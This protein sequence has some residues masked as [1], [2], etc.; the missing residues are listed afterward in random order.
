M[1]NDRSPFRTRGAAIGHR[2]GYFPPVCNRVADIQGTVT[3]SEV[4]EI[5]IPVI[6][7]A[8][9]I[10]ILLFFAGRKP[11]RAGRIPVTLLIF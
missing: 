3:G 7:G 5:R 10:E 8:D 1:S 11:A 2:T 6:A 4:I 9:D